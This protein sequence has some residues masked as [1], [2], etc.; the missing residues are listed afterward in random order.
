T[1]SSPL[2]ELDVDE[3][4]ADMDLELDIDAG[5]DEDARYALDIND[6]VDTNVGTASIASGAAEPGSIKS[7]AIESGAT[8]SEAIESDRETSSATDLEA[9]LDAYSY[10]SEEYEEAEYED[11]P[12]Y[13]L[14]D[15]AYTEDQL[16]EDIAAIEDG[17]VER[18]REQW[19]RQSGSSN[20]WVF[21]G[22]LGFVVLGVLGFVLS[23]PCTFGQCDRLQAAQIQGDEAI[24]SLRLDTTLDAVNESKKQLKQ[25]VRL[26]DP[27]PVWSPYHA[28][29]QEIL[30]AYKN[31]VTALDRVAE[32]QALAYQAAV[33]SQ[34]PPHPVATW[35][36]IADNW[37]AA[38]QALEAVP[39]D[40]VVRDLA[41]RKLLEYRA[42][43]AT[44]LVRIDAEAKAEASLRQ[45]QQAATQATGLMQNAGS[46]PDWEAALAAWE[47]AVS[48]L[49]QIPQGT[50]AHSEAQ[51][52]LPEYR[53]QLEEVRDRTEQERRAGREL[54]RAKQLATDAQ[55]YESEDQWTLSV[56]NWQTALNQLDAVSAGTLPH[57]EAQAL[58]GLYTSYLNA[59]ENNA[60]I[61]LRFQPVEPEFFS[62]CGASSLQKCTYSVRGGNVR[63]DL[64]QGYDRV[65]D[66]SI[67]PPDQRGT[68][69]PDAQFVSQS[70]QLLAQITQ[71]GTQAQVPIELY[72]AE[73]DFM[74]RYRPDLNG[75]VRRQGD[76]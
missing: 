14:T 3:S 48:S 8:E 31:Q 18:Q 42:N 57:S 47:T 16:D 59:A 32:A 46:L 23:R 75:F 65:I 39:T 38:T 19:Q 37:L 27:I 66:Q 54:L 30:P 76:R 33:D 28:Q 35:N 7:G 67:T 51:Q 45:A 44:A 73:G 62:A 55:Q 25:A 68:A 17:E 13:E 52:L 36:Q 29:A 1:V 60:A 61:A 43:R 4:D 50:Q 70:N 10:E 74:A 20:R 49:G 58:A 72:D 5:E 34:D 2:D 22:A 69:A 63:L 24:N 21:V 15:E 56:Q 64:F 6:E 9:D 26:L 40:S 71:L 41:N 11:D 12:V 53:Q